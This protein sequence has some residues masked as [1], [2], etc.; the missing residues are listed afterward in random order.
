M[1]RL[2]LRKRYAPVNWLSATK[3]ACSLR[4]LCHEFALMTA[5][6]ECCR[7]QQGP[8]IDVPAAPPW[9]GPVSP[10]PWGDPVPV[11]KKTAPPR[12]EAPKEAAQAQEAAGRVPMKELLLI[13]NPSKSGRTA[14]SVQSYTMEFTW[15]ELPV[16]S[17]QVQQ[18]VE[19]ATFEALEKVLRDVPLDAE[20]LAA[21]N[22]I[23]QA[24]LSSPLPP[25]GIGLS[26]ESARTIAAAV[27][28]SKD[29][30]KRA[31]AAARKRAKRAAKTLAEAPQ[32]A[33][34]SLK[35]QVRVSCSIR[36]RL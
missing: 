12:H 28:D 23:V 18:I 20:G 2:F 9:E 36:D 24:L 29:L 5:T 31:A 4:A 17:E 21:A 22:D 15:E 10:S 13:L 33:F 30:A 8:G 16:L 32:L 6:H 26:K 35:Q 14:I 1:R 11:E 19:S 27:D 3:L 7:P 34:D 25:R